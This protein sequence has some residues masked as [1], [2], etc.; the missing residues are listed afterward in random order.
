VDKLNGRDQEIFKGRGRKQEKER[1]LSK[2][3]RLRAY[4]PYNPGGVNTV[5]RNPLMQTEECPF[6]TEAE[7]LRGA[8]TS[9]NSS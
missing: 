6:L 2:K 3:K 1:D 5:L 4:G 7:H 8:G 9:D